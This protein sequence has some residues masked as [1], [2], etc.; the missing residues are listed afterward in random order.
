MLYE[1]VPRNLI[2]EVHIVCLKYL[3]WEDFLWFLIVEAF[4]QVFVCLEAKLFGL[5]TVEK[6]VLCSFQ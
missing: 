3:F 4:L 2:F 6:M 1:V 5:W